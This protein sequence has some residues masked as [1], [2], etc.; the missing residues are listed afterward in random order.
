MTLSA[1]KLKQISVLIYKYLGKRKQSILH[2][3]IRN[4]CSNLNND[5]FN[6]HL[7]DSPLCKCLEWVEDAEHYFFRCRRFTDH[8]L[9]LFHKTRYLHPLKAHFLLNG[10]LNLTHND[11]AILFDAVQKYIKD[12]AR[13]D[14]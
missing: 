11:N 6:N 4:F 8:R 3:R 12:T 1:I 7:R 9:I 10:N 13:F 14:T 2:C 5:L